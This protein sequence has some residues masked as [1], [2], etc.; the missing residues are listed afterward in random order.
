MK[1]LL[2]S[3]LLFAASFVPA[4]AQETE[5][6]VKV[7]LLGL[8][9]GLPDM[10][11]E[12][13]LN[14]KTGL[15]LSLGMGLKN[16]SHYQDHYRYVLLPYYRYYFGH[17]HAGGFFLE[18]HASIISAKKDLADDAKTKEKFKQYFGLGAA[19]GIKV[20]N[21]KGYLAEGYAGLGKQLNVNENLRHKSLNLYPRI[22]ISVGKRF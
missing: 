22:G 2:L 3:G 9:T 1:K 4:T 21:K 11:Y 5:N 16:R 7:N 18:G 14:D 17:K 13:I 19:I 10:S 20:F 12:R 15:G 6:E 8:L